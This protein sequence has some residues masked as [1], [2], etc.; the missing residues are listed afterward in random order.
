MKIKSE[1]VISSFPLN[2]L[3]NQA[4]DV[5]WV[6]VQQDLNLSEGLFLEFLDVLEMLS[7]QGEGTF[8]IEDTR[9]IKLWKILGFSRVGSIGERKCIA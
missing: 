8:G 3:Q 9:P 2:G 5:L 7:F 1:I 4:G 6:L